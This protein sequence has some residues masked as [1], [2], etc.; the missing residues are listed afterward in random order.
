MLLT[1]LTTVQVFEKSRFAQEIGAGIHVTPN[2]SKVLR[3]HGFDFDLAKA[4]DADE[5]RVAY[6]PRTVLTE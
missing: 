1:L 2:A 4:S 6:G 3:K 5:V